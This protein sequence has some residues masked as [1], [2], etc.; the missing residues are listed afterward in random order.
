LPELSPRRLRARSAD[1]PIISQARSVRLWRLMYPVWVPRLARLPADARATCRA[2]RWHR[3]GRA[4][5]AR[6]VSAPQRR[7]SQVPIPDRRASTSMSHDTPIRPTKS[8]VPISIGC[9]D[10]TH[11]RR[12]QPPHSAQPHRVPDHPER[13]VAALL[14]LTSDPTQLLTPI[15]LQILDP[16]CFFFSLISL[17]P[18]TSSSVVPD[19][20][21]VFLPG[22]G[23]KRLSVRNA[24]T[25]PSAYGTG[26]RGRFRGQ[27][28]L[29]CDVGASDRCLDPP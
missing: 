11:P 16:L 6:L 28:D 10:L 18:P 15:P 5:A 23:R 7:R 21:P 22:R 25:M 26:F 4:A 27:S 17:H 8:Q 13:R 20:G 1:M 24:L 2:L 3:D 29:V 12:S 14:P 19:L 9:A